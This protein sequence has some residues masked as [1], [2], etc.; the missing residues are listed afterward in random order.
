MSLLGVKVEERRLVGWVAGLFLVIQIGHGLGAN[1]ADA[2]FFLRFGVEFLPLMIVVSGVVVM[3]ATL[4]YAAGLSAWGARRLVWTVPLGC[5][6]WL[7]L[8]RVG[9]ATGPA[10]IYPV[11]WLSAQIVMIVTFTLMWNLAGEVCTT[12]QAKRLFPLFASAGIAGG[13][14]GNAVTGPAATV[15]GTENLLVV[16]AGLLVAAA[17]TARAIVGRF[18]A[19]SPAQAGSVIDDLRAGLAVTRRTPLL[20]LVAVSALAMSVLFFLVM[21]PFSQVV[22]ESFE[23]EAQVAGYLG[24]FSSLATAATLLVSLL[25]ANRLFARFGVVAALTVVPVVYAA[26]FAVWLAGFGLVSASIVRGAQ[27]IAVNAVGGTAFTSLFNVL[28]GTRR[29]QVMA[30]V[31]AVPTQIGTII[32]GALLVAA[33]GIPAS[34]RFTAGLLI[35]VATTV[36]VWRMRP[37]Y[38]AALVSAV[39]QGM[40]DVFTAPVAGLPK[41]DLDADALDVLEA[42]VTDPRPGRRSLAARMLSRMGGEAAMPLLHR[43]LTDEHPPVRAATLAALADAGDETVAGHAA[44]QLLDVDPGVRLAALRLLIDLDVAAPPVAAE[45]LADPDPGVQAAAARLVG[46]QAGS[47]TVMVLLAADDT[48]VVRA[49]LEAVAAGVPTDGVDLNRFAGHPD[50]HVRAAAAAALATRGHGGVVRSLLDDPSP[51]VR[52]A[53]A[54]ALAGRDDLVAHLIEVLETGSITASEAAVAGLARAGAELDLRA[55]IDGELERIARLRRWRAEL[56]GHPRSGDSPTLTFLLRVLAARRRR[57]EGWVL[58]VLRPDGDR[59]SVVVRAAW[60]DDAETRAQAL[61]AL[62]SIADRS[63][64]RRLITLMEDEASSDRLEPRSVLRELTQDFD[65]W[66]RALAVRCLWDD[67]VDDLDHIRR[68]AAEDDTELVRS[69]VPGWQPPATEEDGVLDRV[70]ALQQVSLFADLDPEEVQPIAQA[71][72][73]CRHRPGDTVYAAGDPGDQMLIVTVGTVEIR[74]GGRLV[75]VRGPGEVVGELAVIRGRPRMADVVAGP[76]GTAGLTLTASSLRAVLD[77]RP[78]TVMALLGTLAERIS[79]VPL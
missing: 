12:R 59:R 2:L 35:A 66:L 13:V 19:A 25:V 58:Q 72:Q 34:A 56:A 54:Q 37:A 8:E 20:R 29:S 5:A 11:I 61:E 55:W 38:G 27:W 10:G 52:Q 42:A 4:A 23:T 65:P 6:A 17:L 3:A 69:A 21:F 32:S 53:A 49:G 63:I 79:A 50:R 78:K 70:L 15:L 22:A 31:T 45:L 47:E 26:G 44:D 33:G 67:L 46:G 68:A 1:T 74:T 9:V 57:L 43:L 7:T 24:L 77:E 64:A 73:R 41:P 75:A 16:H 51:Q 14:I 28:R 39:E 71:A 62:E 18:V 30:F 76:A 60:S 36:L 48:D 40:V